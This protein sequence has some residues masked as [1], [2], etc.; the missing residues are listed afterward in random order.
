M[1]ASLPKVTIPNLT[2]DEKEGLKDYWRIY[3]AHREEVTEQLIQMANQHPEFKYIMQNTDLQPSDEEQSRS[4]DLQRNAVLQNDWEPYLNNLQRQGMG[5]AQA[6]LSFHAWFE[7]V[8]AFRKFM[9]PH[10]LNSYGQSPEHL[11]SAIS[12]MD[13]LIDIAMGIIGDSYLETKE[14]LIRTERKR[15]EEELRKLNE[16]L[17][18]RVAERTHRLEHANQQLED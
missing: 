9:M 18:H 4:H 13:T 14:Q 10:L 17:E 16:D 6:G 7:I 2:P 15:G 1:N 12:G 5:Y 11:L 8:A 3:E